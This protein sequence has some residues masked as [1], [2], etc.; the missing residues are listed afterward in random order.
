MLIQAFWLLDHED[1]DEAVAMML[2]PLL[3]EDDL[4]PAHHRAILV[5][6]LAQS[7][8]GLALRYTRVRRPPCR[9]QEDVSL[10]IAVLLANGAIQVRLLFPSA[11]FSFQ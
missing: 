11:H 5:S 3:Q 10:H 6:L 8:P 7:Q 2:D 9:T 1:W 4:S